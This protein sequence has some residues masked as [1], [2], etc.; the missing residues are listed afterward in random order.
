VQ[1]SI[2]CLFNIIYNIGVKY[3]SN[4]KYISVIDFSITLL[5]FANIILI[6][7]LYL[8]L[9]AAFLYFI[10]YSTLFYI[11]ILK[12]CKSNMTACPHKCII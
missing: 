12:R 6:S 8:S 9:T 7:M 3:E 4:L 1:R 11:K 5:R 2:R 10:S